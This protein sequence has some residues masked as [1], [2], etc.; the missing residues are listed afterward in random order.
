MEVSIDKFIDELICGFYVSRKMSR[1]AIPLVSTE[2]DFL[3]FIDKYVRHSPIENSE[4]I[5]LLR[6]FDRM[7]REFASMPIPVYSEPPPV[8]GEIN[9]KTSTKEIENETCKID[10][11]AV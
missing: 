8:S 5:F 11:E 1:G 7:R 10:N 4:D 9:C 2:N 6:V 3:K